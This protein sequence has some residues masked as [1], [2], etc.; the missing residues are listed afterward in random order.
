M[1]ALAIHEGFKSIKL[2]GI[3]MGPKD[4]SDGYARPCME[5]LL[6][7]AVGRGIN[8][9]VSE[10]CA[11]LRGDLYAKNVPVPSYALEIAF[12]ALQQTSAH[13]REAAGAVADIYR[14]AVQGRA[15]HGRGSV[16]RPSV[17]Q[18]LRGNINGRD[19]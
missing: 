17:D 6:G 8:V 13:L 4:L 15:S 2:Y 11:L 3:S 16:E 1:V 10:E 18:W 12:D 14:S 7:F 19:S 9:W 5:F